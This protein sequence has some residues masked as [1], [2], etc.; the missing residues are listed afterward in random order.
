MKLLLKALFIVW[1]CTCFLF[2][3]GTPDELLQAGNEYLF[4]FDFAQATQ[5]FDQII[6]NNPEDPQGYYGYAQLYL[7][8]YMGN[9]SSKDY[10]QF[11]NYSGTAI[12]KARKQ[13]S[14]KAKA[15]RANLLI[16]NLYTQRVIAFGKAE[17]FLDMIW[18]SQKA[19]SFLKDV[20]EVNPKNYDAYLGQGLFKFALSQVPATFRWALSVIGFDA[21]FKEGIQFLNTAAHKA[22]LTKV[23]SQFY[24]AQISSDYLMDYEG[25]TKVLLEL[26]KKYPANALF[27][28]TLAVVHIK[29]HNLKSANAILGKI[30]Q[31]KNMPFRQLKAYSEFLLGEV[32]FKLNN[33][34]IA[35]GYYNKFLMSGTDKSYTG[36]AALRLA[37]CNI[38]LGLVNEAD[39]YF[40]RA[41]A[42]NP[43]IDDDIFARKMAVYYQKNGCDP[44][45][46]RL[47]QFS[48][49]IDQARAAE[50]VDSLFNLK[51]SIKHKVLL[52]EINYQIG[53][54]YLENHNAKAAYGASSQ[55]AKITDSRQNWIA[56]FAHLDAARAA[57][58]S[59][60][61]DL[62]KKH[63]SEA[64]SCGG[65]EYAARFKM[66]L[67]AVKYS[68]NLL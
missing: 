22:V 33:F 32:Q 58:M 57:F 39:K 67:T 5:C 65:N 45:D 46:I 38:S 31:N 19:N 64:E 40:E 3:E 63:L 6:H 17:K 2:S 60:D 23:E 42:G 27:Q 29:N 59:G 21:N 1:A 25:S 52:G 7:W 12:E 16:G 66:Y 30:V 35:R 49:M 62:G 26:Q 18:A 10:D 34:S 24:F 8:N 44:E 41:K 48:N 55:A 9:S 20:L 13:L 51:N 15:Q 36:L 68:Y 4:N 28:Y 53:R 50:A 37:I 56:A 43:S 14:D 47:I 54:A 11:V 61:S